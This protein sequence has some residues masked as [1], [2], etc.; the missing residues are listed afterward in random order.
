MKYRKLYDID[1]EKYKEDIF[2]CYKTNHLIMDS[3]NIIHIDSSEIAKEFI[4]KFVTA[5][6]SCVIGIFD[7]N[8][9]YLYGMVILDNIRFA[10]KSSAQVH[11]VNDKSISGKK[12]RSLYKEM[13]N[14]LYLDTIYAE[15][16]SIAVHP[17]KICKDLGFKKTGY[18]PDVIPYI[19]SKG[20]EKMYDMQILVWRK[21]CQ[22]SNV[23]K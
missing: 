2:S 12:V 19:N 15:I 14:G 5:D 17:I 22:D 10:N 16:P 18:I 8:E 20:E 21:E 23:R 11:I 1:C 6:D 7:E 9:Q 13:I 4:E 3:Q